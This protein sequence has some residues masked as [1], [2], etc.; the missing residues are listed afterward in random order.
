MA[1]AVP[2]TKHPTPPSAMG[3]IA[4]LAYA[5]AKEAGIDL[6]LLLKKAG[7]TLYQI[8]NPDVRV[9]VEDQISFLNL[10]AEAMEDDHLGFHLA[11]QS[12]LREIG[13]LYYVSASSEILGNALQR[14]ARYSRIVNE[15]VS[16]TYADSECVSIKFDYVG[17]SRHLDRHQI[18]FFMTTLV[19]MCRQLTGLRLVPTRIRFS[20]RGSDSSSELVE[21]CGRDIE[22]EAGADEIA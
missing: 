13:L 4:R 6:E 7:L 17:V 20:H 8:E 21:F 3:G 1:V 16:L 15:G 14:T 22:F 11:Q 18:E 12:D 5:R 2:E 9:M 19:Q 10:V